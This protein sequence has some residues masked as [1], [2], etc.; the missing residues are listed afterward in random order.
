[1]EGGALESSHF[2]DEIPPHVWSQEVR[3]GGG[4]QGAVDVKEG[5]EGVCVS[6]IRS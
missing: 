2:E 3:V 1:M 4:G 5:E 6:S